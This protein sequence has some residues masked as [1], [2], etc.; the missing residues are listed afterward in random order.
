LFYSIILKKR[1]EKEL[2]SR[3]RKEREGKRSKGE[4]SLRVGELKK[5]VQVQSGERNKVTQ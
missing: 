1:K 2:K 3:K 5:K 4:E